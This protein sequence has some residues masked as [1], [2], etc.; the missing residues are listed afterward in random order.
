VRSEIVVAQHP[1]ECVGEVIGARG[2]EEAG[3]VAEHLGHRAGA[4]GDD[5]DLAR[6]YR[7]ASA[8]VYP[9]YFEGFGLPPL[10]AMTQ[11]CPVVSARAGA[12]PEVLG[13]A[14]IFF[15]PADV[16]DLSAAMARVLDDGCVGALRT[17][18]DERAAMFTW[19]RT[20]DATLDAYRA[21]TP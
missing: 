4:R 13:D 14:A 20:V 9:S 11:G 2:I 3:H 18:G 1:S 5:H 8:L 12:M 21:L 10:E 15:D 19:A 17:R 6:L 16:D 7:A